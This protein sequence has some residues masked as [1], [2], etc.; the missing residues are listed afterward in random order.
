VNGSLDEKSDLLNKFSWSIVSKHAEHSFLGFCFSLST[1]ESWSFYALRGNC[2]EFEPHC[3]G[4]IG[5]TKAKKSLFGRTRLLYYV[6]TLRRRACNWL[7]ISQLITT[8]GWVIEPFDVRMSRAGKWCK[9]NGYVSNQITEW[10]ENRVGGINSNSIHD[11]WLIRS[12]DGLSLIGSNLSIDS[13]R[14]E[15]KS[16]DWFESHNLDSRAISSELIHEWLPCRA[17]SME[18]FIDTWSCNLAAGYEKSI[19]HSLECDL[20]RF[21]Y[22]HEVQSRSREFSRRRVN[23]SS[24][25]EHSPPRGIKETKPADLFEHLHIALPEIYINSKN[26]SWFRDWNI[27][28]R[29]DG[30]QTVGRARAG[31]GSR[32]VRDKYWMLQPRELFAKL[33]L[34][35]RLNCRRVSLLARP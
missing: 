26:S 24:I 29:E 21:N 18:S 6:I 19:H 23:K 32:T 25:A 11:P 22:T 2:H 13:Q 20:L 9:P 31:S 35:N 1:N 8:S 27:F 17:A 12:F 28:S 3:C 30:L 7:L 5:W 15:R 4:A 34:Q 16:P 33:H 10:S 14:T